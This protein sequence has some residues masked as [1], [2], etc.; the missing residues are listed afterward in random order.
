MSRPK[1]SK[2]KATLAKLSSVGPEL[3]ALNKQKAK[4]EADRDKLGAE[5]EE[6]KT[7]Y[8]ALIKDIKDIEKKIAKLEAKKSE[9]DAAAAAEYAKEEVQKR[10][11]AL[12][13]EGKSLDDI[14]GMMQ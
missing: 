14:L 5:I 8:K 11:A 7:A 6:K 2:N 12:F 10:V 9:A 4:L 3:D 1:G 13:A